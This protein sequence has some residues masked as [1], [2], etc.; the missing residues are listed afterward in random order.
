LVHAEVIMDN[1]NIGSPGPSGNGHLGE[2]AKDAAAAKL[3]ELQAWSGRML[4]R[5]EDFVRE[6]PGTAVLIALGAGFL[7]GRLARR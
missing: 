4:D 2:D 1:T 3:E 5:V 7:V 6:R